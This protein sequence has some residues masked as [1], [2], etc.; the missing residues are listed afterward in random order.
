MP[1]CTPAGIIP[2]GRRLG[3]RFDR[4]HLPPP[5]DCLFVIGWSHVRRPTI[6][7]S[8]R[9]E[10]PKP[11]ESIVHLLADRNHASRPTIGSRFGEMSSCP[12]RLELCPPASDWKIDSGGSPK[13]L[14][15]IAQLLGQRLGSRFG[16]FF[17]FVLESRGDW[18]PMLE[19]L[20]GCVVV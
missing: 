8:I 6:E 16:G 17:L 19:S 18:R 20:G 9:G 2:A 5:I 12:G 3:G 10:F 14:E 13:P 15:S 7:F 11:P 1:S 4:E